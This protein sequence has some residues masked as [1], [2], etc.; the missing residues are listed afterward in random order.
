MRVR[1]GP[2]LAR[3]R[4]PEQSDRLVIARL[5][6]RRRQLLNPCSHPHRG[7]VTREVRHI[8]QRDGQML[9]MLKLRRVNCAGF[10]GPHEF[11]DLLI[12]FEGFAHQITSAKK[13]MR[14]IEINRSASLAENLLPTRDRASGY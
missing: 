2:E 5:S 3:D 12:V 1:A 4:Q 6:V 9:I 13:E 7:F 14:R 10:E 11:A 8:P